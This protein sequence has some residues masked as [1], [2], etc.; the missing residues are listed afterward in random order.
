MNRVNNPGRGGH[1]NEGDE[2]R[3][4]GKLADRGAVKAFSNR[5]RKSTRKEEESQKRMYVGWRMA[6][7][8][9]ANG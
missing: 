3:E 8:N 9:Q 2:K 4:V 1:E 6:M 7:R 5:P